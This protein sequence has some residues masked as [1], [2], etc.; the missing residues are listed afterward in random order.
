[1]SIVV[2]A[3][4]VAALVLP[5]PYSDR[6][7]EVTAA[8]KQ[9]ISELV[10]PLLLEY[11]MATILRKAVAADLLTVD[12]AD[13]AFQQI[14]ELGIRCLLPTPQLHASALRWAARLGQTKANDAHY[15]ALAE[16]QQS[17][18]WTADRRLASAAHQAGMVWVHSLWE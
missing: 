5:L 4:L 8:W 12:L 15:V 7:R 13:E 1:M 9:S 11:E 2:D 3:N 10:A 16:Q 17:E 14:L 18:L 6:A